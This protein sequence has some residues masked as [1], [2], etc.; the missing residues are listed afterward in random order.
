VFRIDIHQHLWSLALIR[1]L[2]RRHRTPRI[3][4]DGRL[5]RLELDGEPACTVD[6]DGDDPDRRAGLVCMDGLDRALIA[7]SL[8]LGDDED[9]VDAY[10]AGC[11]E[12]P[13]ASFGAW[14]MARDRA[15]VRRRL[16]EGF[17]GVCLPA[18]RLASAA[19]LDAAG[20]LLEQLERRGAPLFVHPGRARAADGDPSWWPALTDYVTDMHRAWFAWLVHGRPA[21]PGLRVVWAMAAGGAPLHAER[22]AARGGPAAAVTDPLSFY[23]TSSYGGELLEPLSRV[24]GLSQLVHGSDRPVVAPPAAPGPLGPGAWEAMT[25]H[26]PARLLGTRAAATTARPIAATSSSEVTYGGIT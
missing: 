7:P 12:L 14:G 4:R 23:D 24:V 11:A 19:A 17:V 6:V 9:L 18:D 10:H 5:W 16:D 13:A 8:A 20:P 22:L 21:H 1:V 25:V 15:D 26:N 2:E 3:R